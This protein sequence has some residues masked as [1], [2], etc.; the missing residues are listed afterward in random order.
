ML[1]ISTVKIYTL[2]YYKSH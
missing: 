1:E 2:V